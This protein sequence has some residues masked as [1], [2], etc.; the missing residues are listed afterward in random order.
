MEVLEFTHIRVYSEQP[1]CVISCHCVVWLTIQNIPVDIYNS[2][3]Q[4]LCLPFSA[5]Y[6]Q[7]CYEIFAKHHVT[8]EFWCVQVRWRLGP[9]RGTTELGLPLQLQ[10]P[11]KYR[12]LGRGGT[13]I[14]KWRRQAEMAV[15]SVWKG[16]PRR[17]A[18]DV[19]APVL[20]EVPAGV[21]TLGRDAAEVSSEWR[22]LRDDLNRGQDGEYDCELWLWRKRHP[23]PFWR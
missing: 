15:P 4:P 8:C 20:R 11:G 7:C 1:R 17:G 22:R 23:P 14:Q 3:R 9:Q 10:L 16:G 6:G 21:S 2:G 13:R 19:W 5:W 12:E 18:D